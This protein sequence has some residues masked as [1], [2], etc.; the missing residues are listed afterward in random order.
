M[1]K[2]FFGNPIKIGDA[3]IRV[4][5]NRANYRPFRKCVVKKLDETRPYTH[6]YWVASQILDFQ[7]I[8]FTKSLSSEILKQG[9]GHII[10]W[11]QE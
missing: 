4:D 10:L 5:V 11:G 3:G 6:C 9:D 2:D 7:L 1:F 8:Q